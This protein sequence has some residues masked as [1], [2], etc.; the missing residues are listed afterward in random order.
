VIKRARVTIQTRRCVGATPPGFTLIELLVVIAIVGL[1]VSILLPSLGRARM[2]ARQ[3]R[4]MSA[5]RSLMLAFTMYADASRGLVLPGYPTRDMVDGPV[6]V[7]DDTG[8]R[9]LDE[10]AQRYPWR[11]APFLDYEFSGGL[12]ENDKLLADIRA[13]AGDYARYGVDLQYIVSLYPSLGM[14]I[15]FVGGSDRH[16]EFDPVFRRLFGR[17]YVERVEDAVLAHHGLVAALGDVARRTPKGHPPATADD[18]EDLVGGAAGDVA[19]VRLTVAIETLGIHPL[20]ETGRI[21]E[22]AGALEVVDRIDRRV[23]HGVVLSCSWRRDARGAR[24]A[25][26]VPTRGAPEGTASATP[27]VPVSSP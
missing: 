18:L 16:T 22:S 6:R 12:Y 5:A 19:D 27:P 13:G 4:E 11:L 17:V 2:A 26:C 7:L 20:P 25:P 23:V 9:V 3:T 14:N 1:L 21:G 10:K 8:E 24:R 15:A